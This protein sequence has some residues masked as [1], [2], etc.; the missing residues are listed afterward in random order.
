MKLLIEEYQYNVTDVEN[1]L[2]GLFTLQDVKQKVSV[3]YVGYYYNPHERVRDVVFILPKVLIDE[4]G[5]VF[6]EYD[7]KDLIHLDQAKMDEKHRKFLYEFA[8]WIH[9]AIV[10]YNDSHD[11]NEIVFHRQIQDEGKGIH[12]KRSNTLLDVI[13]SLIR[14]NKENQ[15]FFTFILKNLHSGFNK[16]N[17]N[18]TIARTSAI[19]QNGSPTYL[20]PV[21]KKRQVNFDEELIIIFFSILQ[22]VS[23]TYG[24]R[25]NIN[26]GY[27]LITGAKFKKYLDGFGRTRLRQIKY[28]YFSDT[29]VRLWDLCYA[30]F[31]KAYKIRVNTSQ[32]EYLLVKSFH[33]VFE[34]IIDELIGDNNIPRG[35]KEQ[36][37]GKLVDHFYTYDGLL[38]DDKADDDIYYIGDSKYYKIGN[39]LG[40]ESIYKQR[41]YARNVIQWNIDIWLN[42]KPN[43]ADPFERIQLFDKVTEGYNV[44]PNFFISASIDK[45]TLSYADYTEPHPNQPPVSRQFKNRLYDRDTLL[46]SHYD[47]NF[48][49]VLALYARNNAG[50]KAAWKHSVRDK[51]RRAVQDMLKEKFEFYALAAHPDVNAS[52]YFK[53]HFQETLGKTFRPYENQ[54]LFSLALD[55]SFPEEN[56]QLKASLKENF[57][58]VPITLGHDPS[59]QLDIEREKIGDVESPSG[60]GKFLFGVVTK[61]RDGK[62]GRKEI[63]K[64]YQAFYNLEA[65]DYVMRNMPSGDISKARYFVPMFDG[66]ISGYYEIV[67]ISF[68]SRLDDVTDK[69]GI[70]VRIPMPCLNI[71]L[72][73]YKSLGDHKAEVPKYRNW[74][75]QIHTY[76]ELLQLYRSNQVNSL[77]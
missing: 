49:F 74:N 42:G 23:D 62:D 41:T 19:V 2:D 54:N 47:V 20:N 30:F 69:N 15:Q 34:A 16:I 75:G 18:K 8:V 9:R 7:P 10:V 4:E 31:D 27:K 32:S 53:S 33:I 45:K 39:S 14:F 51:F 25:S 60:L 52:D 76:Q 3:S 46:L 26:F 21:N 66:G 38:I 55:R 13:L 29:A 68:G 67:D 36:D 65:T 44:I 61:Y 17:W 5:K 48:L 12:K 71:K 37:D 63:T 6:G 73:T 72:G 56:E 58:I 59:N 24:F 70:T 50:A 22:Y 64:E 57:Y 1:V 40:K 77:Q 28:K 43:M 11:R 35:L